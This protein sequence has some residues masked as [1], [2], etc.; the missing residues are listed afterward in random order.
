MIYYSKK[1]NGETPE[2]GRVC[3]MIKKLKAGKNEDIKFAMNIGVA[4][5]LSFLMAAVDWIEE[6]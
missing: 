3:E 5:R 4:E 6:Q 1:W 2:V